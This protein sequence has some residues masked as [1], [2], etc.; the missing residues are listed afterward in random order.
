MHTLNVH[1]NSLFYNT[2]HNANTASLPQ[3]V[4]GDPNLFKDDV[5]IRFS[6]S[7]NT[8]KVSMYS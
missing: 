4:Q 7:Y 6:S 8:G 2:T 3:C 1:F 5:D